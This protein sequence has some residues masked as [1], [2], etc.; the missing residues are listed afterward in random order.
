MMRRA[1]CLAVVA[2]AARLAHADSPDC[3][4]EATA[5]RAR[6]TADA[7]HARHWDL[8]WELGFGAVTLGQAALA[9][10]KVK[11]FGVFDED[12]NELLIVGA[13][14]SAFAF[15]AHLVLPLRIDVPPAN[16]DAC[17]DRAALRVALADAGTRER[18]TFW[19]N[20][21]GALAVNLAGAIVLT[22]RRS[23]G[24]GAA[25]AALGYPIGLLSVYTAPRGSWHE[26][27]ARRA[28]WT[29]GATVSKVGP[30]LWLAGQF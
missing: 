3:A 18:R 17:A 22:A 13:V 6:L 25:S 19:L 8:G 27:R 9:I 26:W 21:A 20:H 2:A 15:T 29:V 12:Y 4:A 28:A 14:Q 16:A 11:P 30:S 24:V 5:L 1:A 10:A 7:R 23:I